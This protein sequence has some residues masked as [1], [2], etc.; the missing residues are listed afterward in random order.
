M[1]PFELLERARRRI[2]SNTV[3]DG[4][5]IDERKWKETMVAAYP[6]MFPLY[7]A[8]FAYVPEEGETRRY[9][10]VMDAHDENVS[11]EREWWQNIGITI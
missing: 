5:R 1:N 2:G 9:T 4:V 6:I 10:V 8:E 3:V 11:K 7:V